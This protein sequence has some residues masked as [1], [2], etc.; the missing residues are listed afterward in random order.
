M[1]IYLDAMLV[2]Y[3]ADYDCFIF[4]D[5]ETN[6]VSEQKL[7]KELASL[8]QL[9]ELEQFGDWAFAAPQHLMKELLAGMPTSKRRRVY[10]VLLQAWQEAGWEEFFERNEQKVLS[11]DQSLKPLKLK[12]AADRRH[13][14]EAIALNASWFLTNDVEVIRKTR[15]RGEKIGQ[16][17]QVRVARPSQC[18]D[19]I[20]VGLFLKS[21]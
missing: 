7:A 16:V 10:A 6:P 21:E 4:G 3:C 15:T 14:S 13:L 20:S 18:I 17:H 12:G 1:L 5:T 9:V 19:E 11:I 2:Q 8:R